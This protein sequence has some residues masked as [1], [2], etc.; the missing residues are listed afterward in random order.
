MKR[1]AIYCHSGYAIIA[2]VGTSCLADCYKGL[3][4]PILDKTVDVL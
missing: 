1:A 2:L 4:G 3:Q